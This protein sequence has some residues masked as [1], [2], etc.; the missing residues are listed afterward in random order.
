MSVDAADVVDIN[1]NEGGTDIKQSSKSVAD[2][3]FKGEL[4]E[5]KQSE[6]EY[7]EVENLNH[8]H[9]DPHFNS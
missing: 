7:K 8:H 1:G 3:Y 9:V 2:D 6:V 5:I 4:V